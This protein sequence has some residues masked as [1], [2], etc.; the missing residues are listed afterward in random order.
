ME[1][2][3]MGSAPSL[4]MPDPTTLQQL[5]NQETPDKKLK[6]L[7]LPFNERYSYYLVYETETE[8]TR[9]YRDAITDNEIYSYSKIFFETIK[10]SGI[11]TYGDS[12]VRDIDYSDG[13]TL[14]QTDSN[15]N[16]TTLNGSIRVKIGSS[17]PISPMV[18]T[19]DGL[20]VAQNQNITSSIDIRFMNP[21]LVNAYRH[22]KRMYY[23]V[24]E[25]FPNFRDRDNQ[26]LRILVSSA[27]YNGGGCNAYYTQASMNLFGPGSA[28]STT[29][30]PGAF[31]EDITYHE[32]GHFVNDMIYSQGIN[33]GS[34]HE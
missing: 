20:P 14:Q 26:Q 4:S 11:T 22:S 19:F 15:G 27:G 10:A 32:L 8:E 24:K 9:S 13:G 6:I 7:E 29:C 18:A 30:N 16:T 5:K 1:Y 17:G 33:N 31:Y 3:Y 23:K 28:G 34:L 12:P 25:F 2:I 21:Q